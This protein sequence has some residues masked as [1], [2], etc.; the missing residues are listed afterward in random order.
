[1]KAIT[2]ERYGP[3]SVLRIQE[4]DRPKPKSD[5]VLIHIRAT[6]LNAP[7]WRLLR[8]NS[9]LMRLFSGLFKPKHLIKGT[10]L[11]GIVVEV[12]D[13]VNDYN[14]GDEVY[15]DL[16]DAGFGAF[17]DYVCAKERYIGLKPTTLSFLEAAALPLTAVTALQGVRDRGLI[18]Q[19]HKVLIVGASGGVGSYALQHAK[20]LGAY[21]TAVTSS[22]HMDQAIRL[23]ADKVVDYTKTRLE[24]L[25][26]LYDVILAINGYHPL[27]TY[28]KL[29]TPQGRFVLVGGKSTSQMIAVAAF[30]PLLSKRGGKKIMGLMATPSA[31]DL[32]LIKEMVDTGR[33]KPIIEKTIAFE[34]IPAMLAELEKGHMGGK[35]VSWVNQPQ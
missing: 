3:P 17:A 4:V 1:M 19:G 24:D 18:H 16:A 30:G 35:V 29:L 34:Q 13:R 20:N 14:V 9:L 27:A 2:Q 5:E 26:G 10:D 15:G 12:G 6:S 31:K 11:A 8:G 25:N 33:L 23:G 22:R 21:V 7:D 32:A 28:K